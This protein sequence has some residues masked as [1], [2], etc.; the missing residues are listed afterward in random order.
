MTYIIALVVCILS[1]YA[2]N[3]S[4]EAELMALRLE[5]LKTAMNVRDYDLALHRLRQIAIL[6]RACQREIAKEKIPFSCFE[7]REAQGA[8]NT[9]ARRRIFG[10]SDISVLNEQCLAA[11]NRPATKVEA[12]DTGLRRES[13]LTPECR[14]LY[15][16]KAAI[17]TYKKA[18][19][20]IE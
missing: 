1:S 12:Q 15:L 10:L 16:R 19:K 17:E 13:K 6:E 20:R 9:A 11:I 14:N 18:G 2:A 4:I 3:A 8:V 5:N 7:L